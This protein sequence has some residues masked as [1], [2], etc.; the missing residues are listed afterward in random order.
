[1]ADIKTGLDGIVVAQQDISFIDGEKGDLVYRGYHIN[2]L[3]PAATYEEIV[4]LLWHRKLPNKSEATELHERL[5]TRRALHDDHLNLIMSMP[6]SAR[7]MS[8]CRTGVSQIGLYD[9]EPM[10]YDK[11]VNQL[12]ADDILAKMPTIMAAFSRHRR[13]LEPIPPREDLSHAA[14]FLWMLNGEEPT[15]EAEKGLDLYLVLLA[16]HGFNASTFSCRVTAAT[17]AGMYSAVVSGISTLSGPA[18][19][20]AVQEAMNQFQ[21]IGNVD[22]VEA[23]FEG[24]LQTKKRIMGIGHRVYKTLDPRAPHLKARVEELAAQSDRCKWYQIAA[25]L[26]ALAAAHPYFQERNLYPNVD[27]YSAP[28]LCMLGLEPDMFTPMFAISR[29]AGWAVHIM[30]QYED[31]RLIRPRAEYIGPKGLTWTPIEER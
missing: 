17:W 5:V 27:Y 8:V 23:W 26:E 13:G 7:P 19:G 11:E 1:M 16:E 4:Y 9:P 24:A 31:N 6:R 2:E 15:P 21:E 20:G 22:N 18:H 25:K 10:V 28:L 3:A 14:N 29:V 30:A 12:K